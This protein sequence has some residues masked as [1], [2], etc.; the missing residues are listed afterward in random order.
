MKLNDM[1][2]SKYVTGADLNGR[3]FTVTI[4]GVSIERMRPNPQ[5]P[6]VDKF[7][8]YTQEGK[9]GIVLSKS[10]AVQ[11]AKITGQDDTDGW[12]GKKITIYPEPVN[13]GGTPRLA[14]RARAVATQEARA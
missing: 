13:V 6:E 1:F 2:P 5:S 14:I 9:K 8:L 12:T 4:A 11:I 10:L 7:V 3:S